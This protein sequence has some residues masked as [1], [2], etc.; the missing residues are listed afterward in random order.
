MFGY[1]TGIGALIAKKSALLQLERPWFAGGTIE[2]VTHEGHM[3]GLDHM[4]F[5]DG[6]LNYLGIPAIEIGLSL[7]TRIGYP[8]I[9]ERIYC[10]TSYLLHE[11]LKLRHSNGTSL[12]EIYGPHTMKDRGGTLAMNFYRSDASLIPHLKVE[13]KANKYGLCL[14]SGCVCNPHS[15]QTIFGDRN[16]VGIVRISVGFITNFEDVDSFIRFAKR[17]LK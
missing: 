14:R 16:D 3:F 5:E 9:Y 15:L 12:I 7:L 1:P 10:L 13:K 8:M 2:M 11:L 4:A 17:F 6:T